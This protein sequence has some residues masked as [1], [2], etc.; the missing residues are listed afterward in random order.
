MRADVTKRDRESVFTCLLDLYYLQVQQTRFSWVFNM[1][2][3]KE[4]QLCPPI[5]P[6]DAAVPHYAL[7]RRFGISFCSSSSYF[8]EPR[9]EVSEETCHSFLS[10]FN[11]LSHSQSVYQTRLDYQIQIQIWN[12][13]LELWV[14]LTVQYCQ[15]Y[16]LIRLQIQILDLDQH[17]YAFNA[18]KLRP[19]MTLAWSEI[20]NQATL[21]PQPL[22]HLLTSNLPNL[23]YD[24]IQILDLK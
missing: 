4:T 16:L 8:A 19:R 21:S 11:D 6:L 18:F 9:F 15:A 17:F 5:L 23:K 22:P 24:Q 2:Y 20:D 7:K 10:S 13:A 12:L 3:G 14:V 1:E